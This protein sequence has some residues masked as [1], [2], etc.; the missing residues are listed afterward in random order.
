MTKKELVQQEFD[1]RYSAD[2]DSIGDIHQGVAVVQRD[3]YFGVI[4]T[5]G[6][7][8]IPVIYDY[9]SDFCSNIA[10]VY[11]EEKG[12]FFNTKG[13]QLCPFIYD[14]IAIGAYRELYGPEFINGLVKVCVDGKFGFVNMNCELVIQPV[15]DSAEDFSKEGFSVVR[16]GKMWGVINKEGVLLF[17][18][19][20]E[21]Y[22]K[23]SNKKY[24][25]AMINGKLQFVDY[26]GKVL[27]DKELA[28]LL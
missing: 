15:Y 4:N 13:E 3:E 11:T 6:E 22:M 12:C 20:Y 19:L 24:I 2:Y 21:G 25:S 27:S 9:I 14:D 23:V 26:S 10:A 8:I 7:I 1:R 5:K 17:E 18:Y 28:D 16:K